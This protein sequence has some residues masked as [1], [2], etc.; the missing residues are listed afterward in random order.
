MACTWLGGR[1]GLNSVLVLCR[2]A[3]AADRGG[4]AVGG[5]QACRLL[6]PEAPQRLVPH[7]A[8]GQEQHRHLH[9][10]QLCH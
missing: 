1:T 9:H 10:H 7:L 3:G 2:H 6:Q 4:Q 5:D 8:H